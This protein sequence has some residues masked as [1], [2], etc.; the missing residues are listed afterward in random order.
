[1]IRRAEDDRVS[2]INTQ[3]KYQ[4]N[5]SSSVAIQSNRL[6]GSFDQFN[7]DDPLPEEDYRQAKL[8]F[9]QKNYFQA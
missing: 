5:K 8:F 7:K 6:K 2:K 9:E 1:M 3:I 4:F